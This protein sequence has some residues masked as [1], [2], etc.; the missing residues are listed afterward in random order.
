MGLAAPHIVRGVVG[1]DLRL[2]LPCVLVVAPAF[3]LLADVLG[4]VVTSPGDL[5][6]GIAVAV[7]GGPLF[8]ALV[9]SRRVASL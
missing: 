7:L 2:L 3:L 1:P 5:Q 9:R 4:R 8:V 6:T